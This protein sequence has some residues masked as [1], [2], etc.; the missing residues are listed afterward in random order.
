[1]KSEIIKHNGSTIE[2]EPLNGQHFKLEEMQEIVAGYIEV[3]YLVDRSILIVNEEAKLLGLP[4][5]S[6]ATE[7]LAGSRYAGDFIC[8]DALHCSFSKIK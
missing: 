4:F 6:K 7:S 5:N 2:V 1:M 3:L 8:G